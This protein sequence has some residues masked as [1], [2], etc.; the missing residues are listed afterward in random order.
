ML[1]QRRE[2]L[3]FKIIEEYIKTAEPV[4][5][6]LLADKYFGELSSAT[7]RNEMMD[8]EKGGYLRQ[9]HTSAGRIP[10]AKG[11][12]YYLTNFLKDKSLA[13]GQKR[14]LDKAKDLFEDQVQSIKNIAKAVA[15]LSGN[16]VFV[17][18]GAD[19]VYY[20]GLTNLFSQPEFENADFARNMGRII[21]HLDEAMAG[22]FDQVKDGT[23]VL[24]GSENPFAKECSI[25]TISYQNGRQRGI[26]GLLG[27]IRMDYEQNIALISYIKDLINET[28]IAE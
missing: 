17:G 22:L 12:R 27:P 24:I 7:L 11:Y 14:A 25:I 19:N 20:T 5:S 4:G 8:L 21:D 26:F 1:N 6:A 13:S 18:F 23:E 16:T 28:W 9:P 3:L 15:E 10:T 2:N